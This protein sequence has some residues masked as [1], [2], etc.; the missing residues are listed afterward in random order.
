[1]SIIRLLNDVHLGGLINECVLVVKDK[2]CTC[3][4]MDIGTTLYLETESILDVPDTS[5]GIGNIS[6][7]FKYLKLYKDSEIQFSI[8][9][10]RLIIK[11]KGKKAFKYLTTDSEWIPVYDSEWEKESPLGGV[12]DESTS[13]VVISKENALEFRNLAK[14]MGTKNCTI[15]VEIV[16]SVSTLS[17]SGGDETDHQFSVD[18]GSLD[19][20][21]CS[22]VTSCNNLL[23]ILNT[24]DYTTS[25]EMMIGNDG[26]IILKSSKTVWGL[27]PNE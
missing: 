7:L 19:I 23:A 10:E 5:I 25:P 22:T 27:R 21:P 17:I 6:L 3:K 8:E 18:F 15:S 20:P 2:V 12:F 1:M 26:S 16:D 14:M 9:E 24:L 4:S 13:S 11:P